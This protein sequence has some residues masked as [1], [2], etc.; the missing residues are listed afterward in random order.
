VAARTLSLPRCRVQP[1]T[2]APAPASARP[3]HVL[4]RVTRAVTTHRSH[5]PGSHEPSSREPPVD[6]SCPLGEAERRVLSP[7]ATRACT[8]AHNTP[9]RL[10]QAITHPVH[11]RATRHNTPTPPRPATTHASPRLARAVTTHRSRP[12]GSHEP[13]SREPP[14]D[15]SRPLGEAERRVPSPRAHPSRSWRHGASPRDRRGAHSRL[16][17]ASGQK[18]RAEARRDPG[19]PPAQRADARARSE[20]PPTH[21]ASGRKV[22]AQPRRDPG[23]LPARGTTHGGLDGRTDGW[24]TTPGPLDGR[25]ARSPHRPTPRDTGRTTK[26]PAPRLRGAGRSRIVSA[27]AGR[28]PGAPRRAAAGGRSC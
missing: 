1:R 22:R 4:A 11:F 5:P 23:V 8:G 28:A 10:A 12:P 27:S 3:R 14:V 21:S 19:V 7:R 25:T 24:R 20:L 16:R 6:R 2:R 15:R 17:S 13:S 26:R 9:A 18:V